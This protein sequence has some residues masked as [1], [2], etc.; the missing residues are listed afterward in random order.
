M[1]ISKFSQCFV[2]SGCS[3]RVRFAPLGALLG[4]VAWVILAGP[5]WSADSTPILTSD[6]KSQDPI[7]QYQGLS[8]NRLSLEDRAALNQGKE[9]DF[10]VEFDQTEAEEL[11]TVHRRQAALQHD[12]TAILAERAEIYLRHKNQVLAGLNAERSTGTLKVRMDYS[13][14]PMM[15]IRLRSSNTL[16]KLLR[17]AGIK[18]VYSNLKLSLLLTESLP[19]IRQPETAAQ[20][21][22]GSGTTVAVLDTGAD[23]TRAAFGSCAA[24]GGACKVVYARDFAPDDGV[25]DAHGH[26]TNV[27]GIVLGVAPG[28]RIAALDVFNGGGASSTDIINAIN[29]TIANKATYNIVAMNLSL[30]GSSYSS[31]CASDLF[32][33][34]IAN[35]RTAGIP[36]AIASGNDGYKDRISSPACVPAAVSV[37]AVYDAGAQVDTVAYF[38]NSAN[39]LTLLAP[40]SM[41]TAAGITMQGT[42]QATPHVAGAIA[43]LR[44]A[45]P[46]ESIDAT[47]A[48]L[49]KT[50]ISVTDSNGIPK[51]RI[52][53]LA[54]YTASQTTTYALTVA[55]AGTGNGMVTSS[56]AGINCGTGTTCSYNFSGN[57]ILTTVPV[58]GSAFANWAGCDSVSGTTCT[59]T[60]S[61]A[62][63]VT[64]TFNQST[65]GSDLIVTA[66]SSPSTGKVSGLIT[67][68]ATV[69]NQGSASAPTSLLA[70][71]FSGDTAITLG[72]IDT[73]WGCNTGNLVAGASITCGGQ[74]QIPAN[75]AP[76][77]YYFG[78]Y[79]DKKGVVTESDEIN[80]GRAAANAIVVTSSQPA[81][82]ALTVAK[83]GTGTGMVTSSPA[84]INCGTACS[85]SFSGNVIL[86]AVPAAG[87]AF[88]SWGGCG[89]VSGTTCTVTMSAA[90]TVTATFNQSIAKSDLIVTAV[91]SPSTGKV[92]GLITVS[93]TVKNQGSASAPTSLLALMFSGD[94]AITLGDIDTGWGC[95][96][97]NLV[98]GASIT[99]GGQIQIPANLAL[100]TY[101]FGAYADKNGVVTES[102]EINNGRAAANA[103]VITR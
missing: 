45:Y 90:K 4:S 55:K 3:R 27:A 102:N 71:M 87:S 63:T 84:G 40:G 25:P 67:V 81:T 82:Y 7:T 23:Y 64:A 33:T 2:N 80:N 97:G 95:N 36:A 29:W 99:C 37:G 39:F 28:A 14:L 76:G 101:Y 58:T 85:S 35:A 75:L 92:S 68:S 53:L 100:G 20:G 30:G 56:P 57:V 89:S 12:D 24:P 48:R 72:D 31:L 50:G 8:T 16:D 62:K 1:A 46:S 42:S 66:V 54:A 94:T 69:K 96:T 10:I 18:A 44:A 74:I 88:A 60:M 65:A 21:G 49:T 38:S 32:A 83:A 77:T 9:I 43:V 17:Q 70:L 47:V 103:I 41:I 59:V 5:A 91:S 11:A 22:L 98:A 19:L 13:N 73:G 6:D 52:N 78:A 61:A 79:A 51:P 15:A 86:T 34:P 93:V 26:G